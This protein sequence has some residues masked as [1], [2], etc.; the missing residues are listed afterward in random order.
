VNVFDNNY[1]PVTQWST[2]ANMW[3][4]AGLAVNSAL[5]LVYV[6]DDSSQSIEV[7]TT[8]GVPVTQWEMAS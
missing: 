3:S 5:G 1:N 8:N 6:A 2:S 4:A 7:F